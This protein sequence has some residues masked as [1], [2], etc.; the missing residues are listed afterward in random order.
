MQKTEIQGIY[1]V[2]EGV[3][4][5]TDNEA[6][7]AYKKRQSRE[8]NIDKMQDEIV[9]LKKDLEEIKDLIRGLAK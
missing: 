4:V 3:L 2:S 5:N 6:L 9:S 7:V 1:K 8:K